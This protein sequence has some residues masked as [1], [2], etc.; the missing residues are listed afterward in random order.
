[1]Q[2]RESAEDYLEAILYLSKTHEHVRSI[3]VVHH[4]GFS[5]P[6][7]SVYLKNLRINGYINTDTNGHITLTDEGM[8]IA[9]KIYERHQVLTDILVKLGVTKEV[10][11]EDACRLEHALS[12]ES[13]DALK[14]YYTNVM[15]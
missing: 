14:K 6:S 5:K 15:L 3:D 2:I 10:A 4:L 7:V 11:L 8:S 1:M 12:D 13:F 9:T